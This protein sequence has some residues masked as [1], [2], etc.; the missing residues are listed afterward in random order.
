MIDP[1][2]APVAQAVQALRESA[3][4]HK[5]AAATHR[6]AARDLMRRAAFLERLDALG[7]KADTKENPHGG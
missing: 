3:G 7:I 4:V 1:A 6:K 2:T 5:R